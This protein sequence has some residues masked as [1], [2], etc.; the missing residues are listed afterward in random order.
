MD[1][2][3][4]IGPDGRFSGFA[5]GENI[6]WI[7]FGITSGVRTSFTTEKPAPILGIGRL[8]MMLAGLAI[9]GTRKARV[10][11]PASVG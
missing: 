2:G 1:A 9:I 6:G 4:I 3:V 8:L 10:R 5:W 11:A 7:N